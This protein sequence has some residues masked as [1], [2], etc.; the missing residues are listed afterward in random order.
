[1]MVDPNLSPVLVGNSQ[2]LI[3]HIFIIPS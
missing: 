2:I 1:M 3:N